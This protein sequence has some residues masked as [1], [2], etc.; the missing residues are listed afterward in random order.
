MRSIRVTTVLDDSGEVRIPVPAELHS[1]ER[2]ELEVFFHDRPERT[3]ATRAESLRS[4]AGIF[5]DFPVELPDD[6]PPE[7]I[8]FE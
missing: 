3:E 6:P 7:P 2:V 1:G 8:D 4:V 5:E